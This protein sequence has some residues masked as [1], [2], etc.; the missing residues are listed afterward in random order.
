MQSNFWGESK[1]ESLVENC[2]GGTATLC[3]HSCGAQQGSS[4]ALFCH[5]LNE[6]QMQN[7]RLWRKKGTLS[8]CWRVVINIL[9]LWS[10]AFRDSMMIP[11]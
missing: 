1:S 10:P 8:A 4:T 2:N 5:E 11:L 3:Y 7:T 6:S 9:T